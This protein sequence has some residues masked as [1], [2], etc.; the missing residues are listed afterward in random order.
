MP[1]CKN[2]NEIPGNEWLHVV[3]TNNGSSNASG[4]KIYINGEIAMVDNIRD[5][6][7]KSI[8]GG[9]GGNI[10]IGQDSEMGVQKWHR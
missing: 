3:L 2:S 6:L 5:E 1:S 7:Y 8:T 4:L 10:A 9:G